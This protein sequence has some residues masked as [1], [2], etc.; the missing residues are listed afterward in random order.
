LQYYDA[1]HAA[2][3]YITKSTEQ[4]Q[5]VDDVWALGD[6]WWVQEGTTKEEEDEHWVRRTPGNEVCLSEN[7][8]NSSISNSCE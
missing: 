4:F 7:G 1:I 5:L 3:T 2:L 8:S 6:D